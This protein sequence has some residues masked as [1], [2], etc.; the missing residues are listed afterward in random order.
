MKITQVPAQ[1]L[2]G[3]NVSSQLPAH[4]ITSKFV[5]GLP[6]YRTQTVL[7]MLPQTADYYRDQIGPGLGDDI[8]AAAEARAILR[9]MLGE[10]MLSPGTDGSLWA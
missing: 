1:I 3:S 7:A 8:A 6:F 2:P 5:D 9:D 4:L 10:L